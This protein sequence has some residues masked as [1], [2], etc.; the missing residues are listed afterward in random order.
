MNLLL[1]IPVLDG[2]RLV[3]V[4]G[5]I[6]MRRRLS[7]KIQ[8]KIMLVGAVMILMLMVWAVIMDI[9]RIFVS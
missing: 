6:I 5:E 4:A 1:P 3:L 9:A 8:E 2:G 7:A